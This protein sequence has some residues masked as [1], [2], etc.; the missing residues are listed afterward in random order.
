MPRILVPIGDCAV[1]RAVMRHVL[2]RAVN[3]PGLEVHLLNV[4]PSLSHDIS[5]FV[6][7]SV[8]DDFHNDEARTALRPAQEQ[9][10]AAGIPYVA[11]MAVGDLATCITETAQRLRCDTILMGASRK[12]ALSRLVEY[13]VSGKVLELTTIPVE[14]IPGEPA[15][16]WDR[17]GTPAVL[18]GLV[19]MLLAVVD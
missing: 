16:K 7:K 2:R 14:F 17:Y 5:R 8:R 4:Q 15:S 13:S 12:D 10:D 11:H 19:A 18:A 1:S 9:L 6:A 3:S